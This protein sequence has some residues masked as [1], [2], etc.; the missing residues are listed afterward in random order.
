MPWHLLMFSSEVLR[1]EGWGGEKA[2]AADCKLEQEGL[3]SDV[4]AL[5]SAPAV[6]VATSWIGAGR[7]GLTAQGWDVLRTEQC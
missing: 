2:Q 3:V 5:L 6:D 7:A 1:Q 4:T